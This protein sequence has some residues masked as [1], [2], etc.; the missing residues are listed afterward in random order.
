MRSEIQF[1]EESKLSM[2]N[3][4]FCRQ[5]RARSILKFLRDISDKYAVADTP[6]EPIIT[7]ALYYIQPTQ[8]P[9]P[10]ETSIWSQ[11][12]I[13]TNVLSFLGDPVSVRY[14][15][16]I[17]KFCRRIVSENEHKIMKGAVWA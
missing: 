11:S 8:K 9:S 4:I 6:I 5:S 10:F 14:V 2:Q 7:T 3:L 15:K 13:V 17:N 16:S 12:L 1:Q